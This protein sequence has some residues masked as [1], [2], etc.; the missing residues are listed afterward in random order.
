MS[1]FRRKNLA[2]TASTGPPSRP[3][4]TTRGSAPE[5]D[6]RSYDGVAQ[7]YGRV[8]EGVTGPPAQELVRLLEI[9]PGS[10][11]LDVGTGTGVAARLAASAAPGAIVIGVDP[12][13][14]MLAEAARK[15]GA[16]ANAAAMAIDVPFRDGA[17]SHLIANFVLG[18]VPN[19]QTALFDMLRVLAP[20]GRMGVTNWAASE[21]DDDF[22]RAWE[23]LA[24]EFAEREI[25]QDAHGRAVPWGERFSNKDRL[26]DALH[27]SGLRDIWVETHEFRVEVTADEYCAAREISSQGRFLHQML[28]EELWPA[29]QRRSR[30]VF[31][32]RFPE[33]FHD[34]HQA[35]VAVGHKPYS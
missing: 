13:M 30:E 7:T 1:L 14:A 15:G 22:S 2:P 31:A 12:S 6:W 3:V 5:P 21:H 19:Y 17:F 23:A 16:V 8:F 25:L 9:K 32:E 29:F 35:I 26:K 33:R 27:E 18:H 11:V 10:R 20:G 24:E 4:R 28:G 34:F